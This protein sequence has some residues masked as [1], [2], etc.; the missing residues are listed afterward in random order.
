MSNRHNHKPNNSGVVSAWFRRDWRIVAAAVYLVI[1][2][3]DFIIFPILTM[4]LPHYFPQVPYHPWTPMTTE[5][6]GLFH[7]AFGAILGVSA[8]QSPWSKTSGDALPTE[9]IPDPGP[10]QPN[11]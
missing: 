5:N 4:I 7:L 8:W 3:F 10:I 1:N 6:G 11:Q 9:P 2:V